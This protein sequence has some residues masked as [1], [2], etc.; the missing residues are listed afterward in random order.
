MFLA[1]NYNKYL[2]IIFKANKYIK[3]SSICKDQSD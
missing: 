3:F 1:F 2:V